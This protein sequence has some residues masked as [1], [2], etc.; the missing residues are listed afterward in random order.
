MCVRG[1]LRNFVVLNNTLCCVLRRHVLVVRKQLYRCSNVGSSGAFGTRRNG[2]KQRRVQPHRRTGWPQTEAC[3]TCQG[4]GLPDVGR[5]NRVLVWAIFLHTWVA[6]AIAARLTEL[7][8]GAK[9]V[10]YAHGA[11]DQ[12]QKR[13]TKDGKARVC[14]PRAPDA[15]PILCAGAFFSSPPCS[16][17]VLPPA[18]SPD[19]LSARPRS[20]TVTGVCSWP[21]S[22]C[23]RG[24]RGKKRQALRRER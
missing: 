5:G 1:K 15:L 3:R 11:K 7:L 20:D 17:V 8:G 14:A 10:Y 22:G 6:V 21:G 4:T 19:F 24:R 9:Q 12:Q 16:V 13:P 18:L 23:P 2:W